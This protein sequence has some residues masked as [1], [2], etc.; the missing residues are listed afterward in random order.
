MKR[1]ILNVEISLCKNPDQDAANQGFGNRLRRLE[2]PLLDPGGKVG[3][4]AFGKGRNMVFRGPTCID[5]EL[6]Q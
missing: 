2:A 4:Y 3:T 5:E 1:L 6:P